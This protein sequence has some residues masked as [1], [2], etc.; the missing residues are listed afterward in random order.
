MAQAPEPQKTGCVLKTK[1]GFRVDE[2]NSG[3]MEETTMETGSRSLQ[4]E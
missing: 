2:V 4:A 1:Y 3:W